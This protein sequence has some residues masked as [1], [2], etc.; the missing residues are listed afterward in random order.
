MFKNY[1]FINGKNIVTQTV[2]A[3]YNTIERFLDSQSKSTTTVDNTVQSET[4]TNV[5]NTTQNQSVNNTDNSIQSE[6]NV[7]SNTQMDLSQKTTNMNTNDNSS[8][9]DIQSS[10]NTYNVDNSSVVNTTVSNTESKMIQSCGASIE[11]AKA[12]VNIVKDE[13]I[14]TNIDAS[15]TFINTGDN[16]TVTDVRLESSI[17]FVGP[18]VDRS[19]MLDAMNDLQC[20]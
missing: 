6:T 1:S 16:V 10:T 20:Q 12:A 2:G 11:E 5:D 17:D 8:R 18:E 9:M 3:P 14:N 4:E 19:C 15:N 13:S 7:E